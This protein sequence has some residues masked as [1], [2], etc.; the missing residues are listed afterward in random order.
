MRLDEAERVGHGFTLPKSVDVVPIVPKK[1]KLKSA[2]KN[3]PAWAERK[4][5]SIRN[6]LS[7]GTRTRDPLR[8]RQARHL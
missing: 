8:D 5:Y 3:Q 2:P 4:S 1:I 7:D 6:L